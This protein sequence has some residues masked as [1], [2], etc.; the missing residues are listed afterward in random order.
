MYQLIIGSILDHFEGTSELDY[1]YPI[2]P[3]CH[4]SIVGL[5]SGQ[6]S[7]WE[8]ETLYDMQVVHTYTK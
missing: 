8:G 1:I 7:L 2:L 4:A 3:R 6:Y 5:V